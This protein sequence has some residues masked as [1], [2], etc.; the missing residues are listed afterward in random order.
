M[1]G[2]GIVLGLGGM[3]PRVSPKQSGTLQS[4]KYNPSKNSPPGTRGLD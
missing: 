4:D 3:K 2:T 1:K